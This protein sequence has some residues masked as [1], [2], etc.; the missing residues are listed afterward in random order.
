M[1]YN[2]YLSNLELAKSCWNSEG[3]VSEPKTWKIIDF[4]NALLITIYIPEGPREGLAARNFSVFL[5][6][7]ELK[8]G[9]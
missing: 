7:S 3:S 6:L 5:S 1:C 8:I 4:E 9:I 2:I